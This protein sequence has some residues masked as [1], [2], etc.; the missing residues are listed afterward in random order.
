MTYDDLSTMATRDMSRVKL[1]EFLEDSPTT[2]WLLCE[3]IL[4]TCKIRSKT[5]RYHQL[6]AS[7]PPSVSK[8]LLHVMM[9][10]DE[11]AGDDD[12]RYE[13]LKEALIQ[14]YTPNKL[15]AYQKFVSTPLLQPGQRPSNLLASMLASIPPDVDKAGCQWFL[16][17][18]FLSAMP[19]SIQAHLLGADFPTVEKMASF[20]DNIV[21]TSNTRP[22]S[23]LD[24][25]AEEPSPPEAVCATSHQKTP[26]QENVCFY[27]RRFGPQAERCNGRGCKFSAPSLTRS[28]NGR[29]GSRT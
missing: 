29:R 17:M 12:P 23:R 26:P 21:G 20:A 25:V 9:A 13:L 3:S 28:G 15:E 4:E 16:Q 14:K 27:H 5:E 11:D 10:K 19:K 18:Q 6:I 2:W 8:N 1:P 24:A 7:L 22:A